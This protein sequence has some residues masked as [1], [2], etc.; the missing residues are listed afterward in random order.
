M[1]RVV[2]ATFVSWVKRRCRTRAKEPKKCEVTRRRVLPVS[3]GGYDNHKKANTT[4][5]SASPLWKWSKPN[6]SYQSKHIAKWTVNTLISNIM[7]LLVTVLQIFLMV[8]V[9]D[10][11]V[12]TDQSVLSLVIISFRSLD[13]NV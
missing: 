6:F 11:N 3:P 5:N 12:F 10:E 2:P 8:L 4:L 1:D 7:F 9:T 13:L